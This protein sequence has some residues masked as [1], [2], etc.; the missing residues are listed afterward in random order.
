MV[1][2]YTPRSLETAPGGFNIRHMKGRIR[3]AAAI[4][5]LVKALEPADGRLRVR[6][7]M[8]LIDF[9]I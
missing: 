4:R 3:E 7:S 8:R 6:D 9:S 5:N 1:P 2:F